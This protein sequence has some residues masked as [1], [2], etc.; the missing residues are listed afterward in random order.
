MPAQAL[1]YDVG[2]ATDAQFAASMAA[3]HDDDAP[4][5]PERFAFLPLYLAFTVSGL[6]HG[7]F[8]TPSAERLRPPP[9][10]VSW[11]VGRWL[12]H[13]QQRRRAT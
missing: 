3:F 1:D 2:Y 11:L 4:L 13:R 8:A 9:A 6:R 7:A 10:V 5:A 12:H